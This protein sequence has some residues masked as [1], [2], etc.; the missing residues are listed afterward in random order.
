M[1]PRLQEDAADATEQWRTG[2]ERECARDLAS[3][4]LQL[5]L[6]EQRLRVRYPIR[7]K[8]EFRLL[9]GN[10][11]ARA[12]FGK[13]YNI[14]SGGI[15]FE[16]KGSLPADGLIELT[17]NWPVLLDGVCH[18]KLVMRGRIVRSDTTGTAVQVTRHE[19]RTCKRPAT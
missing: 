17:M 3:A 14:S 8:V 13:T 9:N 4:P 7:L 6:S 16:A 5:P 10:R 2:S 1:T 18:L 11:V 12:G 15:F 19:F